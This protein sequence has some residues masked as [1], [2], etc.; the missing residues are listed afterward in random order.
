[1]SILCEQEIKDLFNLIQIVMIPYSEDDSEKILEEFNCGYLNIRKSFMEDLDEEYSKESKLITELKKFLLTSGKVNKVS[2]FQ[3]FDEIK[4]DDR[5][6]GLFIHNFIKVV[7]IITYLVKLKS[8]L[9]IVFNSKEIISNTFKN[10]T[11]T[12]EFQHK[13][14]Y[15]IFLVCD[16]ILIK[17]STKRENFIKNIKENSKLPWNYIPYDKRAFKKAL[18]I[19]I[20]YFDTTIDYFN[21]PELKLKNPRTDVSEFH[22]LSDTIEQMIFDQ[23]I[24]DYLDEYCLFKNINEYLVSDFSVYS[25]Q[26]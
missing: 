19:P 7:G 23:Y 24:I 26:E 16:D 1:M 13:I 22:K 6:S 20:D 12:K 18:N 9:G 14:F 21:I 11:K 3:K 4:K 25:I 8:S 17:Y 5:F 15:I 2:L 10:L